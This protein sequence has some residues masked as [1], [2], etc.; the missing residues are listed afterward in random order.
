MGESRN[1]YFDVLSESIG[2]S[3]SCHLVQLNIKCGYLK[4]KGSF[5][6]VYLRVMMAGVVGRVGSLP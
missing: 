3:I 5:K 4:V 6:I 1:L 2:R